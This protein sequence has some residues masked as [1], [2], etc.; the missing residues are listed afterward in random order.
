[1][2]SHAQSMLRRY[3]EFESEDMCFLTIADASETGVSLQFEAHHPI[4]NRPRLT[5]RCPLG[6]A[7]E[8]IYDE[9]VA[10]GWNAATRCL[11]WE[12]NGASMVRHAMLTGG[13]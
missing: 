9:M 13:S 4:L 1:M 7:V 8:D 6:T 11:W 12:K 5:V 2:Q 10:Q 3:Q